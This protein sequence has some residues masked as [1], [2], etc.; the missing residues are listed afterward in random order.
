MMCMIHFSM[1]DLG[2]DVEEWMCRIYYLDMT[3]KQTYIFTELW[4][5]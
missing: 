5:H 1:V 4:N 2:G 3:N